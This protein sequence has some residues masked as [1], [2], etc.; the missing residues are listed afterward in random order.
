MH[1]FLLPPTQMF[2]ITRLAIFFI[3]FIIKF[4]YFFTTSLIENNKNLIFF[5]GYWISAETVKIHGDG[6][7]GKILHKAGNWNEDRNYLDDGTR[8]GKLSSA[9]SSPN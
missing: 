7:G 4:Y 8:S 9:Q 2:I 5:Q 3:L 1:V 6:N